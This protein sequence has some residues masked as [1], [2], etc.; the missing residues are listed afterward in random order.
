ML[1]TA[2][3]IPPHVHIQR[4]GGIHEEMKERSSICLGL[5]YAV[6]GDWHLP[7]VQLVVKSY[8]YH[9]EGRSIETTHRTVVNGRR[10][11]FG[12]RTFRCVIL[13]TVDVSQHAAN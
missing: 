4:E 8:T 5:V 11:Q 9:T 7:P 13:C 3:I 12:K 10:S 2:R 1:V 6:H